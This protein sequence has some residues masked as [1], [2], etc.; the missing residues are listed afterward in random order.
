[1][2]VGDKVRLVYTE[3]L[4]LDDVFKD[5]DI[6]EICRIDVDG[7][8][9]T[10]DGWYIEKHLSEYWE[11]VEEVTPPQI[12]NKDMTTEEYFAFIDKIC[13]EMKTL[14]RAK[15]A[16]YTGGES[17]FANFKEAEMYGVDP[18]VGLSVRM[19]DKMKRLQSFCKQ[20][21]LEVKGEGLSEIAKDFIGYSWLLLG[22]IE[23]KRKK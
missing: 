14:V 17:P 9:I 16:D 19:G 23:E 8:G 13:D 5:G 1:M 20:G 6:V 22:M 21:K 15:N 3:E 10:E 7:D 2:K 11:L 4:S 18:I 12:T